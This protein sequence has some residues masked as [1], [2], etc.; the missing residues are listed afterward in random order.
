M[1]GARAKGRELRPPKGCGR[2]SGQVPRPL[3]SAYPGPEGG[4]Q[5]G[6]VNYS[7]CLRLG[8]ETGLHV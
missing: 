6:D 5:N 3:P 7:F 2:A 8:G 1:Q 4:D